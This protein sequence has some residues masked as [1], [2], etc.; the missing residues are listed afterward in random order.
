M[1][2]QQ[3][4]GQIAIWNNTSNQIEEL[5]ISCG[6]ESSDGKIIWGAPEKFVP[7]FDPEVGKK[8]I[9]LY[10]PIKKDVRKIKILCC[11]RKPMSL[12]IFELELFKNTITK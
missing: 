2:K 8:I 3:H 7:E 11:N 4:V 5:Q 10:F 12:A 6:T 9:P 1:Q